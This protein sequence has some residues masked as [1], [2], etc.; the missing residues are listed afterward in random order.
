MRSF[1]QFII[2]IILYFFK[3]SLSVK[4][5]GNL[6]KNIETF[7]FIAEFLALC[8]WTEPSMGTDLAQE[9]I[10]E[11]AQENQDSDFRDELHV[12]DTPH[13]LFPTCSLVQ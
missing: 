13:P 2:I 5:G 1:F 6:S 9:P 7:L 10:L 12:S 3:K 11:S 4:K 8:V